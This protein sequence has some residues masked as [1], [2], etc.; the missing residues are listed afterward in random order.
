MLTALHYL[1]G[2]SMLQHLLHASTFAAAAAPMASTPLVATH[3][4]ILAPK[5]TVTVFL[6]SAAITST[7]FFATH[8]SI[9]APKGTATVFLASAGIASTF[10]GGDCTTSSPIPTVATSV[11]A[12]TAGAL[13]TAIGTAVAASTCTS[14]LSV[15]QPVVCRAP[16]FSWGV[17][18]LWRNI[19]HLVL[20][21]SR[22]NV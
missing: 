12:T 17:C 21:N 13:S 1:R 15:A 18:C 16:R 10:T 3:T 8:S 22:F 4:S 7:S 2:D 5:G 20:L 14:I 11:I 9:L 19:R 6:A